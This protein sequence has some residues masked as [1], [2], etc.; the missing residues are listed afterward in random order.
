MPPTPRRLDEV[1]ALLDRDEDYD[2]DPVGDPPITVSRYRASIRAVLAARVPEPGILASAW[3]QRETDAFLA[4]SRA[5]LRLVVE[6]IGHALAAAPTG[7]GS[8]GVD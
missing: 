8:G 5:T 4:G 7:D 6:I 1:R 3:S 2:E